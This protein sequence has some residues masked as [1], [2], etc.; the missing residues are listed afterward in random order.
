MPEK[1]PER[2]MVKKIRIRIVFMVFVSTFFLY[3][4]EVSI[5]LPIAMR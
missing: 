3:F 4:Y 2:I 1:K 5:I